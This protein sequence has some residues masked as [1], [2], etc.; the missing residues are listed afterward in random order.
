MSGGGAPEELQ[1]GNE[2]I[3]CYRFPETAAIALAR[4]ARYGQWRNRPESELPSYIDIK[5]DEAAALIAAALS[6][7]DDWLTVK[8]TEALFSFYGLPLVEQRVTTSPQEA[9]A[10]AREMNCGVVIKAIAPGVIHKTEARALRLNVSGYDEAYRA[11]EEMQAELSALG[12]PPTGF[13]VQR[14]HHGGVEML[15]GV[16]HDPQ[17]GPVVAC[18]AGGTQVELLGDVSVRLTPLTREDAAEMIRT[19]K[20]F[21]LLQGFR[22]AA[23]CDVSALEDGLLRVSEM[24]HD[25][26]QIA[27]L[28]CNP[29]LVHERGAVILDARVRVRSIAPRPLIGVRR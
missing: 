23:P 1:G 6:R 2:R 25:L 15:V 14:M 24:V 16:V 26:P 9:A 22:G 11:A 12:N 29:F 8:E 13:V 28:D 3:P 17:F 7:G 21:P 27:E 20:T 19:L 4:A 5:R 18:G 10:A